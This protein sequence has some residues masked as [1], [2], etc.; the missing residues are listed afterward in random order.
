MRRSWDILSEVMKALTE[1]RRWPRC[2]L[3]VQEGSVRHLEGP[4]DP[5]RGLGGIGRPSLRSERLSQRS[6][7]GC[8]A[9]QQVRELSGGPLRSSVG[10][11]RPLGGLGGVGGPSKG[12]RG[13]GRL[14]QSPG[15]GQK[16]LLKVQVGSGGHPG[17]P[18]GPGGPSG[19]LVGVEISP[20][21]LG[22]VERPT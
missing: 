14:Y 8:E 10:V 17:G 19:S 4:G 1:V 16:A 20:G 22:G 3:E 15:R 2:P 12:L 5:H 7:R 6:G 9:I 21:G 11:R 13:V 18:E